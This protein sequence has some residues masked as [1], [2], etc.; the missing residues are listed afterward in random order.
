L[1]G[2]SGLPE[3]KK[4]PNHSFFFVFAMERQLHAAVEGGDVTEVA[5]IL[6]YHPTVNVNWKCDKARVSV[7]AEACIK[8]HVEVLRLL[9]RHPWIDVNITT[10]S[11]W[12]PI[13]Y[14]CFKD[15]IECLMLLLAH[16]GI[17]VNILEDGGRTPFLIACMS[18]DG[19]RCALMLLDDHRTDINRPCS[20]GNTALYWAILR[21]PELVQL[22]IASGRELD[23]GIPEIKR[24]DAMGAA[25]DSWKD[26]GVHGLLTRYRDSPWETRLEVMRALRMRDEM[27][28]E[29]FAP[30]VFL[31]DNLLRIRENDAPCAAASFFSIA[32]KL[33][34]EL[35]MVLSHRVMGSARTNISGRARERGFRNFVRLVAEEK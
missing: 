4:K 22:W 13:H 26:P 2:G 34:Q 12:A 20:K 11:G 14:A 21:H 8:N 5:K 18:E 10:I 35:Q 28:A 25:K 32:L 27:A 29:I 1:C 24:S 31:S 15:R 3:N 33:P 6:R 23:F 16:P 30:M 7:L 9:L 17:N 19:A